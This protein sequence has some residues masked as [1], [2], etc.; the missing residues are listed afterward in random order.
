MSAIATGIHRPAASEYDPYY[1]RYIS[2]VKGDDI[3]TTLQKQAQETRDLLAKVS[4]EKAEFRYASGKWS[5]KE[6]L[7]HVNDTERIMAYRILRIARGDRTPIEGFEQD[8]YIA[9]G[10]FGRRT[11]DDLLQEFMTIRNATIQLIR[12]LDA[13]AA[14][15][16]G[17]ANHKEITARAIV[18]VIAG[19]ELHHRRILEEKY[20]R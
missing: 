18:Y 13:E 14:E 3:V 10:K 1:E 8:D 4:G 2:L 11:V 12:H 7:G 19:H 9:G 5:V 17:T 6:V 20:L 16:R 15:Q